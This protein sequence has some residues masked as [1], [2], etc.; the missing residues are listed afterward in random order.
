MGDSRKVLT[1]RLKSLKGWLTQTINSCENLMAMPHSVANESFLKARLEASISDLDS[2][3][4]KVNDCLRELEAK[5]FDLE[6][7]EDR[8]QRESSYVNTRTLVAKSH[9]ECLNKLFE[10][11]SELD[12]IAE[13]N[14]TSQP[15]SLNISQGG[16]NSEG[17]LK[18]QTTLKPFLLEKNCSPQQFRQWIAEFKAFYQASKLDSLDIVSQQAFFR[19]S[20]SPELISVLESKIGATTP[21]FED[22]NLPGSDSCI[23]LLESEF[24]LIYPLVAKRF[25]FFNLVQA[26]KE[27]FTEFLAKVKSHSTLANLE[28]LGIEGMIIYKAIIGI[29]DDYGDLR[30]KILQLSELNMSSVERIARSYESAQ[31]TIREI[32][33]GAGVKAGARD[34]STAYRTRTGPGYRNVQRGSMEQLPNCSGLTPKERIEL[35]KEEGFCQSCGKHKIGQNCWAMEAKCFDCGYFGHLSYLCPNSHDSDYE[36]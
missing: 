29:N 35:M 33:A 17:Y 21:I 18:I 6:Y 10:A 7:N 23:G 36:N 28:T 30:E 1:G 12:T 31:S 34:A 5:E 8:K 32:G 2:R 26:K 14:A 11:L 20:V 4:E 15:L 22:S 19:K 27:T 25:K 16:A 3:F 24:L 9:Q 13:A